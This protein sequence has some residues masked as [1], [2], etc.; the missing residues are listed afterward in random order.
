MEFGVF[1]TL[2]DYLID[3]MIS[4]RNMEPTEVKYNR[5]R[6]AAYTPQGKMEFAVGDPLK[7]TIERVDLAKRELDLV[8]VVR[9]RG[10]ASTRSTRT[11]GKKRGEKKKKPTG[12]KGQGRR[13][14]QTKRKGRR[15]R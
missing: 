13:K 12:H 14:K 4:L 3:G 8:P 6:L 11:S 15:K 9:G 10:S 2:D 5:Y 1:C 7:V